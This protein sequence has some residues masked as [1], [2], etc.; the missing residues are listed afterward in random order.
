MSS[1]SNKS[2]SKLN[3]DEKTTH[4]SK[5][6]MLYTLFAIQL[7]I[8]LVWASFA[9]G[10]MDPF[11]NGIK[12]YWWVALITGILALIILL[13]VL[14]VPK[15]RSPPISLVMYVL[16]TLFFMYTVGY[17][18]VLDST[19][20]VYYA[21][22]LITA[23]AI[24]YA[25]YAWAA[26][27]GMSTMIA[28]MVVLFSCLIIFLIFLIF[29]SISFIG[30]TL[31]LLVVLVFGFY[32]HY[33]VRKVIRGG[34]RDYNKDDPFAGAVTIWAEGLLVFFRFFEL[35]GRACCLTRD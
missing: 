21:L 11:G 9:L 5:I 18:C 27:N 20:L 10:Y 29:T 15:L 28:M 30:L 32:L 26:P 23:V 12:K 35:L 13:A 3:I 2:F 17:F 6:R 25:I 24:G 22:W 33:D 19:Y 34:V 14:F 8:A 16:F 4:I 7:I 1:V 31:V